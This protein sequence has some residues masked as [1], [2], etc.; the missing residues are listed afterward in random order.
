M[1]DLTLGQFL[2]GRSALHRLDARAK[3]V[4]VAFLIVALFS[5]RHPAGYLVAFALVALATWLAQAPVGAILRGLRPIL[6]LLVITA[7]INAVS[8]PGEPV[9]RLGPLALSREGLSVA[10]AL[11]VRLVLLVWATT[12][13]TLTTSPMAFTDGL[14][15]IFSPGKR[16]G[17]P[18]H[19]VALMMSI[20]LRF[21]PTMFEEADRIMKA[22]MAR[23][24]DFESGSL[25]RRARQL[26]PV[27]VPLFVAS[28]RRAEE[29]A[30]A[31][32][33]RGY[34]GGEGRTHFR[35]PAFTARDGLA[36]AVTA[37]FCV[38]AAGWGRLWG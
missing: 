27:L 8:I 11:G 31:M 29:L 15:R 30:L 32:E 19:E 10:A 38:V 7:A 35:E 6:V 22:Q 2:P 12:L 18:V 28:F 37:L 34:A 3:L 5:V 24:A 4:A 36:V 17:L 23:G 13:L 25:L 33:A 9:A 20:A 1:R 26:V 14:E 16:L 21:I